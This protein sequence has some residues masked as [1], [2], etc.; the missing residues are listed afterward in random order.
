MKS[1]ILLLT[2]AFICAISA[3]ATV[4]TV[5]NNNNSPGQYFDFTTA[6]TAAANGDTIYV[7]GSP[8]NYGTF[9]I[10]K[11]LTVYGT[12]HNPQKQNINRSFVD[13]VNFHTGSKGSRL[14]GF[15][16][17]QAWSA[18]NDVDSITISLCKFNYRIIVDHS[19]CSNWVI[20]N[21]VF[22]YAGENIHGGCSQDGM[23]IRNNVLNGIIQSFSNCQNNYHYVEHN[24]FLRAADAFTDCYNF[25]INDNIF[26]RANPSGSGVSA[27][28]SNNLSYQC[29][30]NAFPSG[31]NQTNVNPQFVNLPA[32]GAYFDYSYDFHV[33][34]TGPAHN[35]ATDGTD[36]GVYGG[37]ADYN[38][39]GIPRIP[40]ISQFAISNPS[41][42]PGGTLNVT[43]KSKVR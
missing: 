11:R 15:E 7:H 3:H 38:Q 6:H 17:Y 14:I 39:N 26:Y 28:W 41:V 24:V 13:N 19:L 42:A 34:A 32:A 21:N 33:S 10:S 29:S 23:R 2:I 30:T 27:T 20:E 35:A 1:R 9:D 43:F 18:D 37:A 8:Y 40:Y 25:Y 36:I 22:L 16:V 31:V 12:G 5:S 4:L